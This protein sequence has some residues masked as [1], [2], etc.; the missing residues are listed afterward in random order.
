MKNFR[1]RY[2]QLGGHVHVR[3]FSGRARHMTHARLGELVFDESEW[4]LFVGCLK[5]HGDV[6]VEVVHEDEPLPTGQLAIERIRDA[7]KALEPSP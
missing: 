5:A 4:L 6:S 2:R 3:I 7:A 1:F